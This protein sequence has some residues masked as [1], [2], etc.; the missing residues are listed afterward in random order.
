[1][2]GESLNIDLLQFRQNNIKTN[3]ACSTH[4]EILEARSSTLDG[5]VVLSDAE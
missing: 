5:K 2:N 1:M 3:Y 4:A